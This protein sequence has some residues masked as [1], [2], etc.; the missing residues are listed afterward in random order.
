[1]KDSL[2][3]LSNFIKNPKE[4]G[5]VAPSSKFLTKEI[6]KNIDFKNSKNIIELGPGLG[7]FTKRILKKS[8]PNTKLFCFEVNKQFCS[9]LKK[10]VIDERLIVVNA[11][12]EKINNNL[13]IFNIQD[14]DFIISGLPL[15]NFPDAKKRA[16]LHEV[17]N[18]LC[19]NGKFILFQY[20]N[21][22]GK[23]LESY[24]NKVNRSFVP[25]NIPPSF[26]YVCEK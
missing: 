23:I 13:K 6:I 5:A 18:S 10:N 20:T 17:K 19:D 7:T 8:K 26:V 16:I 25:L 2:L 4:V 3:L 12:A 9:Y 15:L 14:V 1:M 22:L 11:S 24:F 21:G